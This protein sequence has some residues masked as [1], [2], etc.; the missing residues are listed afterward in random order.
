VTKKKVPFSRQ[1]NYDILLNHQ[2]FSEYFF[3]FYVLFY[4][5]NNKVSTK[6][7]LFH[8]KAKEGEK[9]D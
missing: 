1:Q 5:Y 4:Q 2:S 9:R 8:T 7:I 3:L 6:I